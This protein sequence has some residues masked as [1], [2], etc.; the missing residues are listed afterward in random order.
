MNIMEKNLPI[1][2]SIG[3]GDKV[4]I[5]TAQGSS[6]NIDASQIGG[7]GVSLF[8]VNRLFS[9]QLDNYILDKTWNEI[10]NAIND[11]KIPIL[12]SP[13]TDEYGFSM[14]EIYFFKSYDTFVESETF[15]RVFFDTD[16]FRSISQNGVLEYNGY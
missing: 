12:L 5:V 1:A 7:G 9:E 10:V 2:E 8:V 13:E 15:Y 14:G 11:N 3:E 4:R 6:K 16:E